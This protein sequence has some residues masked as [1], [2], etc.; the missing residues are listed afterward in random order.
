MQWMVFEDAGKNFRGVGC[1]LYLCGLGFGAVDSCSLVCS[2]L[3]TWFG[4][5]AE[6]DVG[7]EGG[8]EVA[9]CVSDRWIEAWLGLS[10]NGPW[11]SLPTPQLGTVGSHV[12]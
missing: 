9:V 5:K 8:F 2:A 10:L 1:Y 7:I 6:N 11:L 4:V 12:C 3:C